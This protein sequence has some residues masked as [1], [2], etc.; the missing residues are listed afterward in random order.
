MQRSRQQEEQRRPLPASHEKP[1]P[2]IPEAEAFTP[3][4]GQEGMVFAIIEKG[5]AFSAQ[6]GERL[7]VPYQYATNPRQ[8]SIFLNNHKALG[9]TIQEILHLPEG[10]RKP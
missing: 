8:W 9:F 2:P 1:A 4:A 3:P 10:A 7:S 6:T 5:P